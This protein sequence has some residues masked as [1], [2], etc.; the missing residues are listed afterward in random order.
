[1][2]NLNQLFS[3]DDEN[4]DSIINSLLNT[5]TA[6]AK[7]LDFI[8]EKLGEEKVNEFLKNCIENIQTKL[9]IMKVGLNLS[10]T[11]NTNTSNMFKMRR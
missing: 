1:M 7:F 10:Q 3:V 8:K 4:S 11:Q 6:G 9:S 2:I 5:F